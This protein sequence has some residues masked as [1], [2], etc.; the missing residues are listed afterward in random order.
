MWFPAFD[1][2]PWLATMLCLCAR[3]SWR[4]AIAARA[5]HLCARFADSGLTASI[6]LDHHWVRHYAE[7]VAKASGGK[8]W[9]PLAYAE[10]PCAALLL[11]DSDGKIFATI[12]ARLLWIEGD[13]G[14][15]MR[16][17]PEAPEIGP[18][19][20]GDIADRHVVWLGALWRDP[21]LRGRGLGDALTEAM[22]L[23]ALLRWRFGHIVGVRRDQGL[24]ALDMAPFRRAEAPLRTK[25]G[26]EYALLAAA[27]AQLRDLAGVTA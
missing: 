12:A 18:G 5:E 26:A 8:A 15:A 13:L 11:H 19:L 7:E 22:A 3:E 24:M 14:A 17:W 21:A 9:S 10:Q 25:D 2:R 16:R 27:R 23:D 20:G 6:V 1:A 4:Q